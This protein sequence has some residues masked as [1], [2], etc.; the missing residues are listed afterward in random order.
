MG[1]AY[2]ALYP[3]STVITNCSFVNNTASWRGEAICIDDSESDDF[4]LTLYNDSFTK[5][6][7]NKAPIFV[8]RNFTSDDTLI[9]VLDNQTVTVNNGS[10]V[11]IYAT[12]TYKGTPVAGQ[13]DFNYTIG[14]KEYHA[15]DNEDGI[16]QFSY[17]VDSTSF[18]VPVTA[19]DS[20]LYEVVENQNG[21]LNILYNP[22]II[23]EIA[24]VTYGEKNPFKVTVVGVNGTPLNGTVNVTI[25]GEIY[26]VKLNNGVGEGVI[27]NKLQVAGYYGI[28]NYP[29]EL[30]YN[31]AQATALFNVVKAPVN[32]N[33]EVNNNVYGNVWGIVKL[34]NDT[35]GFVV[36]NV[37]NKS[38]I[39]TSL[40]ANIVDGIAEFTFNNISVG[41]Y[42][43]E[44]VYNGDRNYYNGDNTTDLEVIPANATLNI[45]VD[46]IAYGNLVKGNV[47]VVGVNGVKLNGTAIV[48]IAG[49]EIEV[50]VINGNGNFTI[51]EILPINNYTATAN[52]TNPNYNPVKNITVFSVYDFKITIENK[53]IIQG[54]EDKVKIEFEIP[55]NGNITVELNRTNTTVNFIDGVGYLDIPYTLKEGNYTIRVYYYNKTAEGQISVIPSYNLWIKNEIN[56]NPV[57]TGE[58]VVFIIT[59]GNNGPSIANPIINS[60]LNYSLASLISF[61]L[62]QGSFDIKTGIWNVG[63]LDKNHIAT[64]QLISKI[65]TEN[66][67]N[68][69]AIL[70]IENSNYTINSTLEIIVVNPSTNNNDLS[71]NLTYDENKE[72]KNSIKA[73]LT[74]IKTGN[75]IAIL[76]LAILMIPLRRKI[77]D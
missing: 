75:P 58:V 71:V 1:G 33:I 48:V 59:V 61:N 21:T 57:K 29:E 55:I 8:S 3:S 47:S 38:S 40:N 70:T 20:Y 49:R 19:H 69:T 74:N 46:N 52:F 76:L 2:V 68:Q 51:D 25:A 36:I 34:Q 62:T 11:T 22:K 67:F 35:T 23:L 6:I 14:G 60:G 15:T 17:F 56:K 9:T 24:N 54:M 4:G 41:N 50:E 16:Y 45:V 30:H 32:V 5:Q 18:L 63:E 77:K 43:L 26:P 73:E 27:K 64:L 72:T 65:L 7:S 66:N 39:V 12:I 44:A 13:I 28:A 37:Y 53:T 10:D 31:S 42:T